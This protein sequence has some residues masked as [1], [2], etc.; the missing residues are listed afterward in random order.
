MLPTCCGMVAHALPASPP[1]AAARMLVP[2]WR[3]TSWRLRAAARMVARIPPA[4]CARAV[5]ALPPGCARAVRMLPACCSR[6][7]HAVPTCCCARAVRACCPHFARVLRTCCPHAAR[8]LPAC[9]HF[10]CALPPACCPRAVA[11]LRTCC[12]H[13]ARMLPACCA[14][15]PHVLLRACSPHAVRTCCPRVAR[16]LRTCC[17]HAARTM[18][19]CCPHAARMLPACCP[20]AARALPACCARMRS[21]TTPSFALVV[22]RVVAKQC[23]CLTHDLWTGRRVTGGL[24]HKPVR[25][26]ASKPD[27]L[28]TALEAVHMWLVC[29]M[30]SSTSFRS[31]AFAVEHIVTKLTVLRRV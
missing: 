17:P 5:R 8:M 2:A 25:A 26:S 22:C 6:A 24:G 29:Q 18:P 7:A 12:P 19:A 15:C 30:V 4:C 13:A 1:Q 10:A 16:V 3:S 23:V 21:P 14:C 9:W 11:W 27:D 31:W 28:W 20:R